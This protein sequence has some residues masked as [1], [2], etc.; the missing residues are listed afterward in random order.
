MW[1][2]G[3]DINSEGEF[4][5]DNTG[6]PLGPYLDWDDGQP[7]NGNQGAPQNCL[8]LEQIRGHKWNDV[9]CNQNN[10]FICEIESSTC[11]L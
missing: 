4:Y 3:N 9:P 7:N 10:R 2:S 11:N 8:E 1:T 6:N 5:W